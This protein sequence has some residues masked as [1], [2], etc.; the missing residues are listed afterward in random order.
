MTTLSK[1]DLIL[2]KAI[3]MYFSEETMSIAQVAEHFKCNPDKLSIKMKRRGVTI[4][5]RK[6]VA[7]RKQIIIPKEAMDQ[8]IQLYKDGVSPDDIGK[9]CGLHRMLIRQRLIEAGVPLRGRR[10]A[11][12]L[13]LS[14]RTPEENRRNVQKAHEAVRGRRRSYKERRQGALTKQSKG[15]LDTNVSEHEILF[16]NLSQQLGLSVT[17]QLAIKTRNVDFGIDGFPIAVEIFGSRIR[18]SLKSYSKKFE[19][20]SR[21]IL[22]AGYIQIIIWCLENCPIDQGS[23]KE[24]IR[25]K[26]IFSEDPSSLRQQYVMLGNGQETSL[27]SDNLNYLTGVFRP[28]NR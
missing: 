10:E 16:F 17:P 21:D 24:V 12:L 27:G 7:S 14:R 1:I 11:N 25:I 8:I 3:E 5:S 26:N 19:Q 2:D 23:V 9:K 4:K 20:R 13:H 15:I 6:T 18:S 28:H 22:D